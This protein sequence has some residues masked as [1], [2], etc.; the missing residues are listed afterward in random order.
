MDPKDLEDS[1]DDMWEREFDGIEQA[2]Q[3][4]PNIKRWKR[5]YTF[6]KGFWYAMVRERRMRERAANRRI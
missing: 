6:S 2:I 5:A 3:Y 4:A 1:I